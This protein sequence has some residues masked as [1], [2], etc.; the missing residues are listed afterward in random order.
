[1]VVVIINVSLVWLPL[2]LFLLAPGLT[3]RRLAEFNGWLRAH[4]T[5]IVIGVLVAAGAIMGVN[6][7]Y[8]LGR[9]GWTGH[10]S[11]AGTPTRLIPAVPH[12][13]RM[14]PDPPIRSYLIPW[15]RWT[16]CARQAN[17]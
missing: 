9:P 7:V 10:T 16:G 3:E 4:G 5:A 6:G 15:I 2:V 1:A 13:F 17:A 14:I 11:G 12:P 8:G